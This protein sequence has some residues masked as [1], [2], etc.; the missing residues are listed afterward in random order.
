MIQSY[1][2]QTLDLNIRVNITRKLL[3]K[4]LN[5]EGQLLETFR[6]IKMPLVL[7]VGIRVRGSITVR[8]THKEPNQI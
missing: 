7:E 1:Q 3:V 8:Q 2:G 4:A 6:K 5:L